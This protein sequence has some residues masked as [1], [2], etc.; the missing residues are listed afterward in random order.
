MEGQQR[1]LRKEVELGK[2]S[3]GRACLQCP[4]RPRRLGI[5]WKM[6]LRQRGK[7]VQGAGG[8]SPEEDIH[9]D[10]GEGVAGRENSKRRGVWTAKALGIQRVLQDS[11]KF[12][13][14][15]W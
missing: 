4:G 13:A 10:K 12:A 11:G 2:L 9:P 3:R 5:M 14:G 6:C 7:L 8:R 15:D 1:C